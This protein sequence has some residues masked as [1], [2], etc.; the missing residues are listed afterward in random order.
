VTPNCCH[1]QHRRLEMVVRNGVV[2]YPL[3]LKAVAAT[4]EEMTLDEVID[5]LLGLD[6]GRDGDVEMLAKRFDVS[7]GQI[8]DAQAEIAAQGL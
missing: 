5:C 1:P 3:P 2:P 4:M 8:K 6:E 7:E